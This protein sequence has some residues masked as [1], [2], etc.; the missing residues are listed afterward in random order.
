VLPSASL[1]L[2]PAGA[3]A[4]SFADGIQAYRQ[5][6]VADARRLYAAVLADA[7]APA[8]DRAG[9]A[10]E[11]ARIAWLIDGDAAAA[12]AQLDR[13]EAIAAGMCDTAILIVRVLREAERLQEAVS[14][15]R[16]LLARCD[17]PA[18]S[19]QLRLQIIAAELALAAG[20]G[21]GR[22][23]RL[24]AAA[25]DSRQ[26]G[27]DA[28]TSLRGAEARLD[29]GLLSGDAEAA[30]QGWRGFFWLTDGDA[31]Q[32]LAGRDVAGAF[33]HGLR[34]G[35]S[36]ADRLALADLLVTLG[37]ATEARHFL[38]ASG[39]PGDAAGDPLWRKLS[40]YLEQRR[41][42]EALLLALNRRLAL[43]GQDQP[44]QDRELVRLRRD[45]API[46]EAL[47]AALPQ[48]LPSAASPDERR[49]AILRA[50]GMFG[51]S[52]GMTSGYPSL[53]LGH[54]SGDHREQTELYGQRGEIRFIELDNMLANGF[55][56]WLWDGNAASG[57]WASDGTIVQ[58]RALY[59][60]APVRAFALLGDGPARRELLANQPRLARE[61]LERLRAA[62]VAELRGLQD[63]LYL[64]L[65]D[66]IAAAARARG[67]DFRAAF[68][69]EYYRASIR[70]S[71][72]LHE[73][74]HI[75][76]GRLHVDD[77]QETVPSTGLEYR[78]KL[79][80]LGLADYPR[81]AFW[82]MIGANIGAATSHGQAN[83]RIMELYRSWIAAHGAEV[84]GY[85]PAI[86]ALAQVDKLTD[87]QMRAIAQAADPLARVRPLP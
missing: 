30:L 34:A 66:R 72:Y 86:P 32:A 39:L 19:D 6:K 9:A 51:T 80:E 37:F 7:A 67:G 14:R 57:G 18:K 77:G 85:D 43:H 78:A 44:F 26:L 35:A 54:M 84:M 22:A 48:P 49:L 13:P 23:A 45:T 5:N 41:R 87:D 42:L 71:I 15:G 52:A 11:L 27:V 83:A 33:R 12:L 60:F 74:R 69:S 1:L 79:T 53:H 29:L 21:A 31:P 40:T 70:H 2:L 58:V 55:E 38:A 10:R 17:N 59:T 4:A 50:Y 81:M 28:A 68:L 46:W 63:R 3:Q 75:I 16:A 24:E 73:T 64:Q 8:D 62:P 56:S 47:G 65:L 25:A 61:D 76:D 20:D 36:A 82:N